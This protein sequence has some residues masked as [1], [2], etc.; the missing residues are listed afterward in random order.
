M[1]KMEKHYE[2]LFNIKI[3]FMATPI[4][5]FNA[6]SAAFKCVWHDHYQKY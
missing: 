6:G 5:F 4:N 3:L 1:T 2:S